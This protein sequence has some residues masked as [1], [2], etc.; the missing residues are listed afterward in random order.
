M[1]FITYLIFVFCLLLA[2]NVSADNSDLESFQGRKYICE[3][4]NVINLDDGISSA[5]IIGKTVA[6]ECKD[7]CLPYVN[8]RAAENN[9]Q[10]DESYRNDILD[11]CVDALADSAIKAVLEHR[12]NLK[13]KNIL[14]I[15][16]FD[17]W[18]YSHSKIRHGAQYSINT[19]SENA[20]SA[21]SVRCLDVLPESSKASGVTV[22]LSSVKDKFIGKQTDS[23]HTSKSEK[24]NLIKIKT[25]FDSVKT[26][27]YGDIVWVSVT[28]H[29]FETA[30]RSIIP[31]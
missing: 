29:R 21:I 25:S 14:E 9:R 24:V 31:T 8:S 11:L 19:L 2:Y 23:D 18:E 17:N 6:R 7:V 5:E 27:E 28:S 16:F 30:F 12:V 13:K 3:R 22:I 4:K 1:R 15:R 20:P 26:S 10:S